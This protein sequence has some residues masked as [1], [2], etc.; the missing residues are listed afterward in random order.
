MLRLYNSSEAK[1]LC[2]GY[3]C[4]VKVYGLN[5]EL[6]HE[7]RGKASSHQHIVTFASNV[8]YQLC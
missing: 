3:A 7:I 4:L 5:Q 6:L 8:V 2:H 1:I